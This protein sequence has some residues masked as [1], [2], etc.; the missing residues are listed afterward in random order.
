MKKCVILNDTSFD[1][2]HGCETVMMNIIRLLRENNIETINT[3]PVGINWKDNKEFLYSLANADIVIINGEGSLHHNSK[4]VQELLP[5]GKYVKDNIGIPVVL[6]NAT[7]QENGKKMAEYMKYF[8][9][10]FVRETMSQVDLEQYGIVSEV[11]PDIT[12]YS[13]YDLS[14]KS[15]TNM[16]GVTDS[17][18]SD[19]SDHLY[20]FTMQNNYI[21]LPTLTVPKFRGLHVYTLLKGFK[22][23][24]KKYIKTLF[25]KLGYSLDTYYLGMNYYTNDYDEYI[26]KIADLK[27]IYIGRY[28]ALCFALKTETPFIAIKSNTHK[29][30]SML[31][32]IGIDSSRILDNGSIMKKDLQPFSKI[33]LNNIRKYTTLAPERIELMFQ[34]ISQLVSNQDKL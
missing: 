3:N 27:F 23:Y 34:K 2:H 19:V 12:F 18:C 14:K 8:N 30:E 29:I 26:Q 7:Y 9:F 20:E 11:V 10:I 33:E 6:I 17:V 16:V 13:K 1:F 28:H 4:R 5:I 21:Y 31:E 32:D 24:V 15:V 25:S 22:F